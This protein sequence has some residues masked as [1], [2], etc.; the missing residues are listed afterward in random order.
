MFPPEAGKQGGWCYVMKLPDRTRF[1][2]DVEQLVK[3]QLK[4]LNNIR[5]PSMYYE[6]RAPFCFAFSS[7]RALQDMKE[8]LTNA[9]IPANRLEEAG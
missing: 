9:G 7:E 3:I 1:V 8:I 5:F 6:S 4:Y 2:N